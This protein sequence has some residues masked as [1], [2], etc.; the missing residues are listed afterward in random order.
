MAWPPAWA[1]STTLASARLPASR[2]S[3]TPTGIAAG[4]CTRPCS[5]A[6]L[7]GSEGRGPSAARLKLPG[8]LYSL[9][10]TVI[11]LCLS[12][13]DWSR[14]R[15]TKGAVKLHLVLDHDGYLPRFATITLARK[16]DVP[17][18][19]HMAFPSGSVVVVD[20]G[21]WSVDL[22]G[23]WL[24]DQVYFVT[25]MKE[26]MHFV[27]IESRPVE[28]AILADEFVE[29]ASPK[30]RDRYPYVMRRIVYRDPETE[31][32]YTYVTNQ[33]QAPAQVIADVY[34]ERWQIELFFKA[35]KQ[36]LKI[37]TFIG[38]SVNA[39][40]TQIWT[41]LIA[42]LL[43]RYLQLRSTRKW[44][45]SNLV[46]LMRWNLFTYRD[47]WAWLDDRRASPGAACGT[48]VVGILDIGQQ[49]GG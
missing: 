31:K 30:T 22:F 25:R 29:F 3:H 10:A 23:Q 28:G 21:Y 35:L 40:M 34:K 7:S 33:L 37:K 26:S 41:A 2:L 39:V 48:A 19:R 27:V 15:S 32:V 11:S 47:L 20:R 43:V 14:Y 9:D 44:S 5:I 13:F 45:F 8:K 46:A 17:V 38:T 4:R 12:V 49:K 18:A 36:N 1:S 24:R 42:M 16:H 6:L